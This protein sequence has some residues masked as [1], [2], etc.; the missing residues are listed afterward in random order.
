MEFPMKLEGHKRSDAD[1]LHQCRVP[2]DPPSDYRSMGF[3]K[4]LNNGRPTPNA[5]AI[6][7]I[8]SAMKCCLRNTV[9]SMTPTVIRNDT[10]ASTLVWGSGFSFQ[11]WYRV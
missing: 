1:S 2:R 9:E 7:A 8:S 11:Y 6:P 5:S 10:T 4:C 3:Q